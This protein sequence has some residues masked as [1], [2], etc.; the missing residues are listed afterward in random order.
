MEIKLASGHFS[1]KSHAKQL[2]MLGGIL[3]HRKGVWDPKIG[4]TLLTF[5]VAMFCIFKISAKQ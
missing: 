4:Q 5:I 1:L 2:I 3:E